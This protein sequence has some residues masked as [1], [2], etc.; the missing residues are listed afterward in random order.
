MTPVFGH[1]HLRLYLL[2]LLSERPMHGYELM[3]ALSDRFGGTYIPSAGTIYPRLSKLGEEG[4]V[5]READGRK[6]VYSIT[7]A[8]IAELAARQ[9]ELDEIE[10]GVTTT[11]R[12][13]ADEVRASV[14]DAMR[15]LRADLAAVAGE[16][17]AP[18]RKARED[19]VTD[20]PPPATQDATV[21]EPEPQAEAMPDR[22]SD[23]EPDARAFSRREMARVE[24]VLADFRNELRVE[25]RSRA[26]RD[27]LPRGTAARL[28]AELSEVRARILG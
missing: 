13:L 7:D 5:S 19:T 10:R 18:E 2:S 16:T 25:L 27:I 15:T 28:E 12:S 8:G 1:G 14:S 9:A 22:E 4:L 20:A 26:G 23:A 3:Q 24:Q 21:D 6:T 11:V 17:S